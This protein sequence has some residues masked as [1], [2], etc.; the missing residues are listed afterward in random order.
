MRTVTL[1]SRG[2]LTA[3]AVLVVFGTSTGTASASSYYLKIGD[4]KGESKERNH[5][6]WID[7]DS[8][9]WGITRNATVGSGPGSGQRSAAI[10]SPLSWTQ[11]LDSSVPQLFSGVATGKRF[12]NATLDVATESADAGRIVY[13]QMLFQDVGLT[14]LNLNGA[15]GNN[16]LVHAAGALVYSRLVMTYWP[17][18]NN[19]RVGTPITGTWDFSDGASAAFSGSPEVLEG[20]ILAGPSA[21]PAPAAVW[22]LGTGLLGL[23]G[24]AWRSKRGTP[25]MRSLDQLR[26]AA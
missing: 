20:L 23:M 5:K 7:V 17:L 1:S 10:G 19:G 24:S 13:F 26:S 3:I 18:D 15:G 6:D 16:E 14:A 11:W 22:L 25:A 8:F 4:I 21:V 9:Y 2:I 12:Q